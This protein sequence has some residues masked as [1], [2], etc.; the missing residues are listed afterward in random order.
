MLRNYIVIAV[1]SVL[2]H[3]FFSA[4]NVFGL[5]MGMTIA[6]AV[7]MLVADQMS[8]DRFNTRRNR[9]YRVSSGMIDIKDG[10]PTDKIVTATSPAPLRKELLEKYTGVEE[11]VRFARNFGNPWLERVD[12][13]VNIPFSGYFADPEALTF[14]E[15]E[16]EFG[17]AATALVKPYSVVLTRETADKLFQEENPMGLTI[18]VGN[19]GTYTVTGVLKKTNHKTHIAF[20]ALASMAT[21]ESLHAQG[22]YGN[23]QTRWTDFWNTW[24]YIR[25]E[26]G[27]DPAQVQASLHRIYR[28]HILH[29]DNPN[30][31]RMCLLLQPLM[32][33]T[34]GILIGNAIGPAL[35]WMFIN[36]FAGLA[37]VILLT[38]CFNFTNLSIAR[39]LTRAREIGV[40]KVNGAARWQ[41]F[42]QFL[43][44]AIL[45]ALAS[46]VVAMVLMVVVKPLLLQL[47]FARAFRWDLHGSTVVYLFI[48]AFAVTVGILAGFFPAVVLSGFEP[49]KV[50]KS[51]R[52]VKL[53]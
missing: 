53:F 16:L 27:K 9:I 28:D 31:W 10:S 51:L 34:P 1:R 42:V 4:I 14:F 36:I 20:E 19:I 13:N 39:S 11:V 35:P 44:E 30:D 17:D 46:L 32:D 40:R 15:Y 49:V 38:S 45:V 18:K 5:A 6:M 47:N 43:T 50:L 41:I 37:G 29:P 52:N 25:L 33:I 23:D 7:I 26:E 12:Q 21:V 8:Y 24:T 22:L 3:K 2:R 48:A